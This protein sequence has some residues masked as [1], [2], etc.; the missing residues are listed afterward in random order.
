MESQK[1]ISID[2]GSAANSNNASS[3]NSTV[4]NPTELSEEKKIQI[5]D[6]KNYSKTFRD[7]LALYDESAQLSPKEVAEM[8]A[9]LNITQP[10]RVQ[11]IL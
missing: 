6:L 2:M 7:L 9:E 4:D 10:H 11:V 5:T 8:C 1:F 3:S